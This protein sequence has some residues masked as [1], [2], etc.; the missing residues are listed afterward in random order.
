VDDS[1]EAWG[2][3][4]QR[5][6]GIGSYR[7]AWR[8]LKQLRRAMVRPDRDRLRGEVEVDEIWLGGLNRSNRRTHENKHFLL[9]AVEKN[10]SKIGRIRMKWIPE[11]ASYV[12]VAGVQE[13]IE[14]GSLVETDGWQAYMAMARHGYRHK[15]RIQSSGN[16]AK[17]RE[18]NLLPRVH[19]VA[20]L[21]KRWIMGTYHGKV[22]LKYLPH[23]LDEFVFRFNRRTSRSRG[24]LFQRLLE[25]CAQPRS[26]KYPVSQT[27]TPQ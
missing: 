26:S 18:E 4:L 14:P 10:G 25:N 22:D 8:L 15:R 3:G 13:L 11:K 17:V 5:A 7:T 24:L 9:V 27:A 12:L 21:F 6:L 20:S 1:A 23:Y 19:K 16:R 2:L